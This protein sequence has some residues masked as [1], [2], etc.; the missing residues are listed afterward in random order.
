MGGMIEGPAKATP[1]RVM[2]AS[3][4]EWARK[5]KAWERG[6]VANDAK[7]RIAAWREREAVQF[8]F[9]MDGMGLG[10]EMPWAAIAEMSEAQL[11]FFIL[12][13]ARDYRRQ[14]MN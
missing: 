1:L 13:T 12:K 8:V 3:A 4:D 9:L 5:L 14:V 2:Q 10:M 7:G 6:D 11:S